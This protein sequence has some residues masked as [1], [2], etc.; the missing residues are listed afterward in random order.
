MTAPITVITATIP[1]REEL[2]GRCLASVYNQNVPV[3]M[4]LVCAQ[5]PIES[6]PAPVHCALM[7]NSL[8]PAV[9]SEWVMRLADDDR[10]LPFHTQTV[11]P[12]LDDADVVYTFDAGGSR[13]RFDCTAW[14]Q[15]QLVESLEEAN[16]FDASAACIRTEALAYVGGWPTEWVDGHFAGTKA[17]Y[18][19]WALWLTLARAGARFVCVPVPTWVYDDGPHPRIST[20][21]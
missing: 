12:Y 16:F 9:T 10:L 18:E 7:Q 15:R 8:L 5:P 6:M 3:V 13:P 11:L 14:P 4:Q 21:G 1:G 17:Y 20:E 2:L 19:D